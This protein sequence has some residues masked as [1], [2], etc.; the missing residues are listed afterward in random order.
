MQLGL[1]LQLD[2][3]RSHSRV[4]SRLVSEDPI[5]QFEKAFERLSGFPLI[6]CTE[7]I[8]TAKLSEESFTSTV[9][10]SDIPAY[11]EVLS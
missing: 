6:V 2:R 3:D 9:G 5:E 1:Y 11:S 10:Y 7:R 4:A 8:F